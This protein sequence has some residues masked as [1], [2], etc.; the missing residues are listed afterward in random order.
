MEDEMETVIMITRV[1]CIIVSIGD[2]GYNLV[3]T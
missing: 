2:V 1:K 3:R